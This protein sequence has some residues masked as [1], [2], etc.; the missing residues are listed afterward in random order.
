MFGN[1]VALNYQETLSINNLSILRFC[2]ALSPSSTVYVGEHPSPES[3]NRMRA[4]E[5]V[6]SKTGNQEYEARQVIVVTWHDVAP[7]S[8]LFF[9]LPGYVSLC[10][11]F[12]ISNVPIVD[13]G[14]SKGGAKDA[15]PAPN[16]L[17]IHAVLGRNLGKIG[18][19]VS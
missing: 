3:T 1:C 10:M 14:G 4:E 17:H 8:A 2:S 19:I 18:Q 7:L 9:G 5:E 16:F 15:S 12:I 13:S 11:I 6:K